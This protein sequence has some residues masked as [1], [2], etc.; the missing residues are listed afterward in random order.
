MGVAFLAALLVGVAWA[1]PRWLG[2]PGPSSVL[3]VS[4]VAV[5]TAGYAPFDA[6]LS[7]DVSGGAPPYS[8]A[9][10]AA[11]SGLGSGTSLKLTFSVPGSPTVTANVTDSRGSRVVG[12]L[13]L[14]VV[15]P[16]PE[17]SLTV[18]PALSDTGPDLTIR[19]ASSLSVSSCILGGYGAIDVPPFV[20]CSG[21][22]GL[23][24]FGLGDSIQLATDPD[25]PEATPVLF[26]STTAGVTIS[27]G[28][29]YNTTAGPETSG[30]SVLSTGI[31]PLA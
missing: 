30:E 6:V 20:T 1:E 27:V 9:W 14:H 24:H 23:T 22:G 29:W 15:S 28:W 2:L 4:V 8:V 19:W 5:A 26:Q 3:K 11:G 31:A 18:P 13:Q 12:T 17:A 21:A 7:V 16:Y 25:D 10:A